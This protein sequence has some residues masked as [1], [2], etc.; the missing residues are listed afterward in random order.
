MTESVI[1][2]KSKAF[3]IRIVR[4][5]RYLCDEKKEF[6]LSK[7]LLRSGTS[8]GANV[9][10]AQ[11]AVS[12]KDFLAKMYVSFKEC[13]ET[14]YWLELLHETGHLSDSE[15]ESI[16]QD[17]TT[18]KKLLSSITFTTSNNLKKGHS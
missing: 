8:I 5:Y 16:N 17:N 13:C 7:Q 18:L 15:F 11:A 2:D 9:V 6:V 4:L 14:E 1:R 10:E 3:A 12:K